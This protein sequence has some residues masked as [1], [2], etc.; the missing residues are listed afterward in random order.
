MRLQLSS[1]V[2]FM[3]LGAILLISD[4]A[5]ATLR[6]DKVE[7]SFAQK[8]SKRD[9]KDDD[10]DLVKGLSI[11]KTFEYSGS[12]NVDLGNIMQQALNGEIAGE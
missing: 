2:T 9:S 8:S 6:P 12:G 10:D 7:K 3:I 4:T 1:F 5:A 11:S